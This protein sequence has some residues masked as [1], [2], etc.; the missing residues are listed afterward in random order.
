MHITSTHTQ[1]TKFKVLF[2]VLWADTSDTD[3]STCEIYG[4]DIEMLNNSYKIG[5][6]MSFLFHSLAKVLELFQCCLP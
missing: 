1:Y 2:I 6:E 3:G 4:L 5:E